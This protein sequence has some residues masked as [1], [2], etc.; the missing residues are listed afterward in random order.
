MADSPSTLLVVAGVSTIVGLMMTLLL[1]T[2]YLKRKRRNSDE[3]NT[4]LA[5]SQNQESEQNCTA[6]STSRIPCENISFTSVEA[7]NSAGRK[8]SLSE[9]EL[10][11]SSRGNVK[12]RTQSLGTFA[13]ENLAPVEE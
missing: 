1:L 12:T 5:G 11:I 7:E 3:E 6:C 9:R 4:S 2:L 10:V 8:E 13:Q